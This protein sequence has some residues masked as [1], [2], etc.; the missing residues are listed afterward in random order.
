M[1]VD[2]KSTTVTT[3]VHTLTISDNELAVIR[4]ALI[5]LAE[6]THLPLNSA[7]AIRA[8]DL[9]PATAIGSTSDNSIFSA[10]RI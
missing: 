8:L 9:L 2:S 5:K 3:V 4:L 7:A 10:F 6:T 1:K